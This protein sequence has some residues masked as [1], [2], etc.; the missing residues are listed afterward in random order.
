MKKTKNERNFF[1]NIKDTY[2]YAKSGK[3]YLFIFL[4]NHLLLTAISIIVPIMTAK[5]LVSLTSSVWH[6]VL[7]I[8]LVLFG[9]EILRNLV[10]YICNWANGKYYYD[11]RKNIQL[12]LINETLKITQTELNDNSSGV[13]I[14]R[15]SNDANNITDIFTQ[16][17]DL[18]L[19]LISNVGV[20]IAVFFINF[21]L[22][23]A[24]TLFLIIN[25]FY[26]KYAAKI[27]YENQKKF[28]KSR[29][30]T[31][32]FISEIVRGS[33]DVKILNAEKSFI[34]KAD[35]YIT[36]TNNISYHHVIVR[37]RL[38]LL[39]GTI[40]DTI[41]LCM[42]LLMIVFL[43][44]SILSIESAIIVY[45]YHYSILNI[46]RNI[47]SLLEITK[48]FNLAANRIFGILENNEFKKEK[49]GNKNI[50][51][52]DFKGNI[53]F[54]NVKFAYEKKLPVIRG[55]SFKIKENE[56]IG[57]VGS[58]GAGKST[59]FNLISAINRVDAGEILFDGININE[60]NKDSIRGNISV[61]SQ[62]AYIY[63][64][65]IMDNLKVVK[66]DATTKEI[67]E[68]CQLACLSEFIESLPNKYNTIV[69]EGGV[70][71]SGGQKQR[72]A[73]ARALL[74][75]TKV[76][77]FDEATSALDNETQ[78][79]IQES[80]NNLKGEY[81]ILIVAHRLSTVMDANKIFVIDNGKVESSGKHKDLLK[82][83]EVYK[84]LYK[85][86]LEEANN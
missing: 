9:I 8:T 53:E 27:N 73:I 64:M 26:Q 7:I 43:T 60:L 19:N 48:S 62:N 46:S 58:S 11:V 54:K 85:K 39:G 69:G 65:S 23:I 10:R 33:K 1:Q 81:T 32:G 51:I 28:K 6:R 29:E 82:K 44:N 57:F 80:I 20:L 40:S 78:T 38:R 15:I 67:K 5:R 12:E 31:S 3:K 77:L 4:F 47:E 61:I 74:L 17:I 35:E 55:M 66:M 41:D 84:R 79:K 21:Y 76:L 75:K 42:S 36:E 22:G 70:T 56:T 59:I 18:F 83:S 37:N 25:F 14:E 52:E 24:Y 63:N 45:N 16:L 13:F 34:K 49:F 72:L 71:L 50:P 30:K 86:E 68:A 2:K